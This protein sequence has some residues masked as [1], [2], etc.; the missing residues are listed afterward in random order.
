MGG[1]QLMHDATDEQ[2]IAA[3]GTGD[4]DAFDQFV[5]RHQRS[6]VKFASRMLSRDC[7]PVAEDLAQEAFLRAWLAAPRFTPRAKA[8][9]WIF[10]ITANL[11]LNHQRKRKWRRLFNS[12]IGLGDLPDYRVD[13]PS[14]DPALSAAISK[15][16]DRQRAALILRHFDHLSYAE[17]AEVMDL[18]TAA[19]EALLFRSRRSLAEVLRPT[20]SMT[21]RKFEDAAVLKTVEQER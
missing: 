10:R 16:P 7:G 11:C 4:R 3:A 5:M 6:V 1:P 9:T 12:A 18:S 8:R 14:T 21:H 15:L 19:V 13:G 2:L 17:I 20:K